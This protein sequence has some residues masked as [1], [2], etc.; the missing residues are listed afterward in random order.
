MQSFADRHTRTDGPRLDDMVSATYPAKALLN[1]SVDSR[2]EVEVVDAE[3][4]WRREDDAGDAMQKNK[5][6]T[7][8]RTEQ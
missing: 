7:D 8:V 2:I 3:R 5:N 4:G 6:K 1:D